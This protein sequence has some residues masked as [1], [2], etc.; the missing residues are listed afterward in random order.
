MLLSVSTYM[1]VEDV[2]QNDHVCDADN[3]STSDEYWFAHCIPEEDLLYP[4]LY[5]NRE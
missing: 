3:E 2:G 5:P 4:N 1:A